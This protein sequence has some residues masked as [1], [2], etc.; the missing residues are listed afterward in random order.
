[1]EE[2]KEGHVPASI[3]RRWSPKKEAGGGKPS[4]GVAPPR[5]P[6]PRRAQCVLSI[7]GMR[8]NLGAP[9]MRL[10]FYLALRAYL[11]LYQLV[12]CQV[13]AHLGEEAAAWVSELPCSLFRICSPMVV[14]EAG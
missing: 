5:F 1:M 6:C 10:L 8:L 2:E 11:S 7:T 14:L 9:S 3:G 12:A 4:R 13:P